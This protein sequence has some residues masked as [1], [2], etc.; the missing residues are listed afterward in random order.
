MKNSVN[1]KIAF[2]LLQVFSIYLKVICT[3]KLRNNF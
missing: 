3:M 2:Y 1:E